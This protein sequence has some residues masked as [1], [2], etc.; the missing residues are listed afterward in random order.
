VTVS[1]VGEKVCIDRHL[2]C[3]SFLGCLPLSGLPSALGLGKCLTWNLKAHLHRG[4]VSVCERICSVQIV[5]GVKPFDG[6]WDMHWVVLVRYGSVIRVCVPSYSCR[7]CVYEERCTMV[8]TALQK[9][10]APS[11]LPAGEALS[12]PPSS[13]S[14]CARISL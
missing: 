7:Y 10:E 5:V 3:S 14:G 11:S 1:P 8:V 12:R 6:I 4:Q 13:G 2:F 9:E